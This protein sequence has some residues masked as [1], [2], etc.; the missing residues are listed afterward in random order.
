MIVTRHEEEAGFDI[1]GALLLA[2]AGIA[3]G[4]IATGMIKPDDYI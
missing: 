1:V 3:I 2:S 4:A